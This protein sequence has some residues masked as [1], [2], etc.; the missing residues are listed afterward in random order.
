M[1]YPISVKSDITYLVSH[2]FAKIKVDSYDS[3]PVERTMTF[4][5]VLIFIKSLFNDDKNNCYY[6]T[7]LEKTSKESPNK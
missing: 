1:R 6:N 2:N 3:L 4:D 7:F 5:N